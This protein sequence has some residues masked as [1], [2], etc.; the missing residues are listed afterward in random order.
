MKLRSGD[1]LLLLL[2]SAALLELSFAPFNQY[3]TAF[4]ALIPL[5]CILDKYEKGFL[6]GLL[7]G[8]FYALFSIHW[9]AFNSGTY[10]WVATLS[11]L[12]ASAFLA[13]NYGFIGLF[14]VFIR[15]RNP[16]YAVLFLPFIWVAVEFLRSFGT[17]G[18][19]WLALGHSQA[20]HTLY[21]QC[22]DIG[23]V[24]FVSFLLLL[25]N[26][27][28]YR[29]LRKFDKRCFAALLAVILIP[30]AYG[31]IMLNLNLQEDT[32][33]RF[34]IVQPN[35]AAKEKWKPEN[36]IPIIEMMDSLSRS[37][38]DILPQVIV[39]PETAVPY[40]LR[41]SHYFLHVI[42]R[43][44][45]DMKSTLITGAL[46]Y[47]FPDSASHYESTNTLF[48]FEP[49]LPSISETVYDK[50]HLVPFGEFT[51]GG[52]MFSWLNNMQYG[53][54]D[55]RC[56][57]YR[58]VLFMGRDSIP[59]TPMIC[60]DS[61]FPHTARRFTIQGSKYIILITNDI[62]FGRSL[63]PHQHA[64]MALL[65]SVECRRPLIRSANA[66]ISMFIDEKGRVLK[67]LPLYERGILDEELPAV[68][69]RSPYLILGNAFSVLACILA[70]PVVL[71]LL[72][73]KQRKA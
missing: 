41:S 17:L 29:L 68:Q 51:P 69:Y 44:A 9:L 1:I 45:A 31:A 59:F 65:R 24:Y 57:D 26:L 73:I 61:V 58:K 47:Y 20:Y 37:E 13:L 54:S 72:W 12:L 49:Y 16:R 70:F 63:G 11:M 21:V 46:D 66:G 56:R 52:T 42:H 3:Y 14:Y 10:W 38:S 36:R 23:G 8:F 5:F 43:T 25:A 33:T 64:A 22:A 55:F 7:W 60:Y 32:R 39:W 2:L 4:F 34:R 27:L 15:R 67:S 40:Y 30:Y 18:F 53:Q 50:I 19:P 48:I 35:V 62:W 71:L 6:T 28:L